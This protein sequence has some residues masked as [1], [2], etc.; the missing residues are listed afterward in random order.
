MPR[1]S[2]PSIGGGRKVM[3]MP[4]RCAGG[5]GGW[6]SFCARTE[7]AGWTRQATARSAGRKLRN[8]RCEM[9]DIK[10]KTE[11]G[12]GALR[13]VLPVESREDVVA[14]FAIREEG[15]IDVLGAHL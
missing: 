2:V 1:L 8:G 12:R 6:S 13:I 10:R 9:A 11:N 7:E 3:R 14:P 15:F 4:V 5:G